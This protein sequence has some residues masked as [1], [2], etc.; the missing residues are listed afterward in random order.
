MLLCMVVFTFISIFLK[1]TDFFL[2]SN[3]NLNSIDVL[4]T[5]SLCDLLHSKK[6][7]MVVLMGSFNAVI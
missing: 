3:Y 2:Y 4:I 5:M 1:D 7:I 6:Y